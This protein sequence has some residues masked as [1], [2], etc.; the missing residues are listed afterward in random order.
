MSPSSLLFN[1]ALEVLACAKKR[2]GKK[3]LGLE[4]K[5]TTSRNRKLFQDDI[6]T[7]R[8][9][10]G[11]VCHA[12]KQLI[13]CDIESLQRDQQN[14]KDSL[15]ADSHIYRSLIYDKIGPAEQ[16]ENEDLSKKWFWINWI[17]SKKNLDLYLINQN[18]FQV[19]CKPKCERLR[20][21]LENKIGEYIYDL[22][23]RQTFCKML[24]KD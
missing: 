11:R 3:V 24:Q 16:Q 1:T 17:F 2:G 9:S 8:K 22:R 5:K 12:V 14:R 10:K 6:F 18:Q 15:E 13:Q 23:K 19:G 4:R 21:K 7:P 20:K